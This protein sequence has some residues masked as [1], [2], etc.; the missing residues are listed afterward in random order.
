MYEIML[1]NISGRALRIPTFT[2]RTIDD[3]SQRTQMTA[4]IGDLFKLLFPGCTAK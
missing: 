1:F 4:N 3:D 2:R